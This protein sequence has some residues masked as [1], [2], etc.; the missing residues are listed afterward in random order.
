[1]SL[2]NSNLLLGGGSCDYPAE[3]D[4][5]L[6][7]VYADGSMIGTLLPA[8][9]DVPDVEA[10]SPADILRRVMITLGIGTDPA[11]GGDWPAFTGQEPTSP[12]D[13]ITTYDTTGQTD[14][15]FQVD[16]GLWDHFGVQIRVRAENHNVGWIK[17]HGIRKRL[18]EEVYDEYITLGSVRYKVN[19]SKVGTVLALGKETNVSRRSLFTINL[20]VTLREC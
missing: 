11:A 18:T 3:G 13:V 9:Y 7:V 4:V 20:Y 1:M 8:G 6:G 2:L 17:A 16:G 14:G 15:R 5:R 12:D 19:V 10:Y